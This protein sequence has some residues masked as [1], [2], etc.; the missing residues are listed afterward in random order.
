MGRYIFFVLVLQSALVADDVSDFADLWEG[1]RTEIGS[2]RVDFTIW[3]THVQPMS[4]EEL[5]ERL[6]KVELERVEGLFERFSRE[7]VRHW[8]GKRKIWMD[9]QLVLDGDKVKLSDGY[10]THLQVRGLHLMF[11]HL[12]E[13]VSVYK[14]GECPFSVIEVNSFRDA[15]N[16]TYVDRQVPIQELE[17]W[18]LMETDEGQ[19]YMDSRDGLP[20]EHTVLMKRGGPPYRFTKYV[21]HTLYPGGM[22]MPTVRVDAFF[23]EQ[24]LSNLELRVI[25]DAEFN[26]EIYESEF[27]V[28]LERGTNWFDNRSH[29]NGGQ[30]REPVRDAIEYFEAIVPPQQPPM[31]VADMPPPEREFRFPFTWEGFL[32]VLNGLALIA[33]GIHFWRR[34]PSS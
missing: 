1:Y 19:L 21:G 22:T 29:F 8:D 34:Q 12:A 6:E 32:L 33:L 17:K 7:F 16:Q 14:R 25:R 4:L 9:S 18:W 5:K 11:D 10:F 3:R 24:G 30:V 20:R 15:P 13:S 26:I 23:N 28:G 31:K 27:V 2:G